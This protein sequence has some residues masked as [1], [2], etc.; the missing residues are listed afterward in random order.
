MKMAGLPAPTNVQQDAHEFLSFFHSEVEL[1][2]AKT[3]FAN[4]IKQIYSGT[5]AS[6]IICDGCGSINETPDN[7]SDIRLEVKEKTTLY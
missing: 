3:P 6:Q 2:F 1:A 4:L 7:F 5:L